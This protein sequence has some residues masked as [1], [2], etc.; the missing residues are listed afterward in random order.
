M[1]I[2]VARHNIEYGPPKL[3]LESV[4]VQSKRANGVHC[5]FVGIGRGIL[6]CKMTQSPQRLHVQLASFGVAIESPSH[7]VAA[8]P[9]MMQSAFCHPDPGGARHQM[10]GVL[11]LAIALRTSELQIPFF[12]NAV[13]LQ[14]P[15]F[16]PLLGID[17]S[18]PE[19]ARFGIEGKHCLGPRAT[20]GGTD[21]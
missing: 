16:K 12:V 5:L 4:H 13:E 6:E 19:L 9:F 11:D 20:G 3:F 10:I 17:L 2:L 21:G 15:V 8:A 18:R 7:K 14:D 1:V